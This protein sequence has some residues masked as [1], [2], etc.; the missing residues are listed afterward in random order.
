MPNNAKKKQGTKPAAKK[1][2]PMAEPT[3]EVVPVAEPI[4]EEIVT[5]VEDPIVDEPI[6]DE[7]T[8]KEMEQIIEADIN[9]EIPK[10]EIEKCPACSNTTYV[11]KARVRGTSVKIFS[12]SGEQVDAADNI[13]ERTAKRIYCGKC[14][15][16]AWFNE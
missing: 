15:M 4:A 13:Q 5:V 12:F 6:A 2:A 14:R 16:F 9:A 3:E 11:V 8:A 7:I 1:T 10:V